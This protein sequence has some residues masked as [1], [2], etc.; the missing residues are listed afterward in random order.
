VIINFDLDDTLLS[1][2]ESVLQIL[3]TDELG[4][5]S[6][7]KQDIHKFFHT[8]LTT[9]KEKD[10]L[11]EKTFNCAALFES[12]EFSVERE[13]ERA[14]K[15]AYAN[16]SV[17]QFVT[18]V[19]TPQ[20]AAGK[21]AWFAKCPVIEHAKTNLIMVNSMEAKGF[22]QA[23]IFFDDHLDAIRSFSMRQHR[24]QVIYVQSDTNLAEELI[25]AVERYYASR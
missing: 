13:A 18:K 17:V 11:L 2:S 5:H 12:L 20:Q 19:T 7:S 6:L 3:M 10:R 8:K 16:A 21:L 25:N 4:N 1:T 24:S 15:L 23:D 14:L 9:E 22:V